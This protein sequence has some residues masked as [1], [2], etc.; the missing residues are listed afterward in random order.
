TTRGGI[1]RSGWDT[2]QP[3]RVLAN[4]I[5]GDNA[6]WWPWAGKVRLSAAKYERAEVQTIFV[7]KTEIGEAPRQ[8]G[9]RDV[10]LTVDVL[11]QPANERV[12]VLRDEC[13]VRADRFQRP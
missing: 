2:R 7:D 13:G 3:N 1:P 9:P 12:N 6:E 8:G 10:D 5:A 4:T 11:L